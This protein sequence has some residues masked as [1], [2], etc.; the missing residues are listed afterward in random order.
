M[1]F[2]VLIEACGDHFAAYLPGVPN[3]RVVGPTRSEAIDALKLEIEHRIALGEL[4]S[5]DVDTIGVTGLAGKY[6]ADATL[7]SICDDAYRARDAE[8]G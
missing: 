2:P 6:A 8:A 1:S 4:L 5:L 3:A 7:R